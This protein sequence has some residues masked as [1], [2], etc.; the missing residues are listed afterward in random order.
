MRTL[1][2]PGIQALFRSIVRRT[3]A[4]I[5]IVAEGLVE[6]LE[7][8][9]GQAMCCLILGTFVR[10]SLERGHTSNG[11]SQRNALGYVRLLRGLLAHPSFHSVAGLHLCMALLFC[12]IL[13]ALRP[14]V[15][16][17]SRHF[18]VHSD[19][20]FKRIHH[21]SNSQDGKGNPALQQALI[22]TLCNTFSYTRLL[23][24]HD[25]FEDDDEASE[26]PNVG[27]I[28]TL[29]ELDERT[30]KKAL[31]A[32]V[33]GVLWACIVILEEANGVVASQKSSE[34]HAAARLRLNVLLGPLPRFKV[35]EENYVGNRVCSG[36]PL[37][38]TSVRRSRVAL[39]CLNATASAWGNHG[40]LP[41]HDLIS[42][43]KSALEA[44]T[45]AV[46]EC[47]TEYNALVRNVVQQDER[48]SWTIH[49][50][51]FQSSSHDSRSDPRAY[52]DPNEH[53]AEA[54][55]DRRNVAAISREQVDEARAVNPT[56]AELSSLLAREGQSVQITAFVTS[57][58][59]SSGY[60]SK[61]NPSTGRK[62][63][64]CKITLEDERR[65]QAVVQLSGR[66]SR[67][68]AEVRLATT[69]PNTS[70]HFVHC[71]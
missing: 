40:S 12:P 54:S 69:M 20:F 43:C 31:T 24:D 39:Q 35:F 45:S 44:N 48:Q 37:P 7:F 16:D 14:S 30:F 27:R 22:L 57:K 67:Q 51:G 26:F 33:E 55:I 19:T 49:P 61:T 62:F 47:E 5:D 60:N 21:L 38:P 28:S 3:K 8:Q 10:Y 36:M 18:P 68:A 11:Q 2:V 64:L 46:D 66:L 70:V 29:Q 41:F 56:D 25:P 6:A 71:R 59:P 58:Q 53:A 23:R 52:E 9:R 50:A 1:Q 4:R 32:F 13:D 65:N 63:D 17:S 15:R 34:R 42:A